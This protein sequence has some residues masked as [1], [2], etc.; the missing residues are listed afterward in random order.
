[1][2]RG[3]RR[4]EVPSAAASMAYHVSKADLL[5]AAWHLASLANDAGS[6]DDDGSTLRRLCDELAELRRQ[7]GRSVPA[8][9]RQWVTTDPQRD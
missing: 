9:V 1:M 3:K 5:E 6:C 2:N 8:E 4:A 7:S